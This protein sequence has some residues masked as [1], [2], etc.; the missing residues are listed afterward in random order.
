MK[1]IGLLLV[2]VVF[3][4]YLCSFM[5]AVGAYDCCNEPRT[6]KQCSKKSCCSKKESKDD[7]E[8]GCQKEHFAFLKNIG[9]YISIQAPSP[10]KDFSDFLAIL[11]PKSAIQPFQFNKILLITI[12]IIRLRPRMM[13]AS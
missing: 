1:S 10:I 7:K 8:D 6:E 11:A 2:L 13:F 4:T 3:E 5:C 12:A 9:Q